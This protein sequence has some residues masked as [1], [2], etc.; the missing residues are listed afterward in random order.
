MVSPVLT[1][2]AIEAIKALDDRK[3]ELAEVP[4]WGYSVYIRGLSG[5]DRDAYE[6]A[7]IEQKALKDKKTGKRPTAELNLTNLRAKLIVRTAVD[8]DDPNTCKPIFTAEDADWIGKKSG[9]ALQRLYIVA[10]RLS[11]L[12]SE[13][14]EEL[15]QE[16]G[17]GGNDD[18]GS[19][20]L[21]STGTPP[22]KPYSETSAP[23]SSP[24]GS[25]STD[26]NPLAVV[27]LT[28]SSPS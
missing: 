10:Q 1:R 8:S 19:D 15:T 3:I 28:S 17:E 24:N 6:M 9:A 14:E 18:S 25:G 21:L 20:S 27:D 4:E 7:M 16:L 11:G 13:D 12:S 2:E 23:P 22:S 26:S 5:I